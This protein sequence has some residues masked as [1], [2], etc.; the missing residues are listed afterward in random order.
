MTLDPLTAPSPPETCRIDAWDGERSP[1]GRRA[2][3]APGW[4]RQ[5]IQRVTRW[6]VPGAPAEPTDVTDVRV[7]WGLV[8]PD[9]PDLDS[10]DR[11]TAHDAEEP[12]RRLLEHRR[13]AAK[14]LRYRPD[15][16][17]LALFDADDRGPVPLSGAPEGCAPGALPRY[18][19]LAGGPDTL[20][21]FLQYTLNANRYT[22]RLHLSGPAL[23]RY[24]TRVVDGWAGSATRYQTPVVWATNHGEA[25]MS[26]WMRDLIAEPV[27][28]KLAADPDMAAGARFLD[29]QTGGAVASATGLVDTL[30]ANRPQLIVTTS[31]GMTGPIAEPDAMTRDLGL[32]VDQVHG[33]VTPQLLLDGW[34]PDGAIW[35]AHACCSAGSDAASSYAGLLDPTSDVDVLLRAI[36][37][38]GNLVAPLPT[39]LLGAERPA[40]AFIGHVEPTF[41]WSIRFPWSGAALTASIHTALYDSICRGEPVGHALANIWRPIGALSQAQLAALKIYN[42]QPANAQLGL[43]AALYCR[44][45]ERDR[46]GTVLLG[47]P[48]VA[49]PLP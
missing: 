34:Q 35:Y 21:W 8:L 42:E 22:G 24:V 3:T 17:P 25:D 46:A 14:V 40:R 27:Y 39:A 5:A 44:L 4:I 10:T 48:A 47:D 37:D 30:A 43:N 11:W 36:A 41:D 26:R 6:Q 32:P 20:P 9:R 45:S 2:G 13:P 7:G 38:L 49:M 29:G 31:H 18:L 1:T 23:D 28:R 12:F 15:Y 19:L 16:G 33:V